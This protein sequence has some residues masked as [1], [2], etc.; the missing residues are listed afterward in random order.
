VAGVLLVVVVGAAVVLL[1]RDGE[2]A[3]PS[4]D[5]TASPTVTT[6]PLTT[7]PPS[8]GETSV[9]STAPTTTAPS[10]ALPTFDGQEPTRAEYAAAARRFMDA[11]ISRDC[12]QARALAT[13][14][15]SRVHTDYELCREHVPLAR[16]VDLRT[17]QVDTFGTAGAYVEWKDRGVTISVGLAIAD[18]E[19]AI[20]Q[21]FIY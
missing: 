20:D 15:F 21:L 17:Y 5:P 12:P 3:A 11:V 2:G 7:Q 8:S 14:T 1:V 10:Y 9:T 16:K 19:I 4:A 13:P 6:S 18:N